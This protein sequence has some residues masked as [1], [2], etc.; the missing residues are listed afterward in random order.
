MPGIY[1]I[2][3][4]QPVAAEAQRR[5]GRRR[6][7][8]CTACTIVPFLHG[9]STD[10]NFTFALALVAMMAVE[11]FGFRAL[12]LGYLVK[13]FNFGGMINKPVFGVIDFGVGLLEL[14]SEFSKIISFAFRLF[15]N[16]FAGG[17]LLS[18]LGR[19]Y[20]RHSAQLHRRARAVCRR[21][22]GLCL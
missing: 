10:L 17:L 14:V 6:A 21:R 20:G 1:T 9:P 15:G 22:A 2:D 12:G 13:F 11:F 4:S 5:R 19:A 18:V 7:G 8:L 16:L 3:G